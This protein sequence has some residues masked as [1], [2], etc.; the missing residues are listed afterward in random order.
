MSSTDPTKPTGVAPVPTGAVPE[1]S[2]PQGMGADPAVAASVQQRTLGD[3]YE[4]ASPPPGPLLENGVRGIVPLFANDPDF[5]QLGAYALARGMN[6]RPDLY[7]PGTCASNV[8]RCI[9]MLRT[10]PFVTSPIHVVGI[11][12]AG[13][14]SLLPCR[15]LVEE[16]ERW[17]H[18]VVLEM[19]GRVFDFADIDFP[20]LPVEEYLKG[21]FPDQQLDFAVVEAG[22]FLAHSQRYPADIYF[23]FA[24]SPRELISRSALAAPSRG[25]QGPL[26]GIKPQGRRYHDWGHTAA[27]EMR[28]GR[29]EWTY[30]AGVQKRAPGYLFFL[31]AHIGWHLD[32]WRVARSAQITLINIDDGEGLPADPL[33]VGIGRVL[34]AHQLEIPYT[35]RIRDGLRSQVGPVDVQKSDARQLI[36]EQRSGR[37][38]PMRGGD[39]D[40][41]KLRELTILLTADQIIPETILDFIEGTQ[42]RLK[43]YWPVLVVEREA[44]SLKQHTLLVLRQFERYFS[45]H[46]LPGGISKTLMRAMLVLHDIGKP[47]AMLKGDA[48][49][50]I[51]H[52]E[53]LLIIR[54]V[55]VRMGFSTTEVRLTESLVSSDFHRIIMATRSILFMREALREG[56]RARAWDHRLLLI[57]RLGLPTEQATA[58]VDTLLREDDEGPLLAAVRSLV[59]EDCLEH[60]RLTGMDPRDFLELRLIFFMADAGSY[61]TDAD[62]RPQLASL[63]RSVF[64]TIFEID[65]GARRLQLIAPIR[66]QIDYLRDELARHLATQASREDLVPRSGDPMPSEE[67]PA[68]DGSAKSELSST[69]QT[70]RGRG[71]PT[72]RLTK[73]MLREQPRDGLA[74]KLYIA[75]HLPAVAPPQLIMRDRDDGIVAIEADGTKDLSPARAFQAGHQLGVTR[76]ITVARRPSIRLIR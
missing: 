41:E 35:L 26:D 52:Q 68:L 70:G 53:S 30:L 46:P 42:D 49:K 13:G 64:D 73:G 21:M 72:A 50:K 55:L 15:V 14:G 51:E 65:R 5:L 39:Y 67:Y 54:E 1:G 61:T 60:A 36:L 33:F 11:F 66:A 22:T 43:R 57:T 56:N 17:R 16:D 31:S 19:Q 48:S 8:L 69:G 59:F 2:I 76:S 47:I 44:L 6:R 12:P 29:M 25:V 10:T 3:S 27:V 63:G 32:M 23:S 62:D 40:D 20:G 9:N 28:A 71:E 18:H 38:E 45:H 75:D 34:A 7:I 4:V 37:A 24:P 74:R 58:L